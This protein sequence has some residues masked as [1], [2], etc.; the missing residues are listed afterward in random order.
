VIL[1][2]GYFMGRLGRRNVA[3]LL[4]P[5]VEQPSDTA[6]IGYIPLEESD[7]PWRLGGELSAAGFDVDL[8]L[9][10]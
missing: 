2:L 7:W 8:N 3:P 5:G 1:E 6:G 10:S 9:L 4:G